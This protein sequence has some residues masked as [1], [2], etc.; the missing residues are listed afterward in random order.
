MIRRHRIL[1][2]PARGCGARGY[3]RLVSPMR[4]ANG[5]RYCGD[6]SLLRCHP[7]YDAA[8]AAITDPLAPRRHNRHSAS[9]SGVARRLLPRL[10]LPACH[11]LI[12]DDG[13]VWSPGRYVEAVSRLH[14]DCWTPGGRE[15]DRPALDIQDLPIGMVMNGVH[16]AR[17]VTPPVTMLRLRT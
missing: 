10:T 4:S 13:T 8:G 2:L 14:E 6:L 16:G 12:A 7:L 3:T 9:S 11:A 1:D 5:Q 17:S 15:G